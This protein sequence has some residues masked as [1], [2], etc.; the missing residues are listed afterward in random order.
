MKYMLRVIRCYFKRMDDIKQ[1]VTSSKISTKYGMT[2]ISLE[3]GYYL[4]SVA[5]AT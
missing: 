4:F 1:E 2:T 5:I 3:N